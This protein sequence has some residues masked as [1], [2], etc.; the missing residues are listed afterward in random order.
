LTGTAS[1]DDARGVRA[2]LLLACGLA[3][4]PACG[5]AQH[6]LAI[7]DLRAPFV[8]RWGGEL[9]PEPRCWNDTCWSPFS[10]EITVEP[11]ET[12]DAVLVH[13]G[14]ADGSGL[15]CRMTVGS[16]HSRASA[17]Q[18]C[19]LE[20]GSSL[21][22][23]GQELVAQ[24]ELHAHLDGTLTYRWRGQWREGADAG[25]AYPDVT[26]SAQLAPTPGLAP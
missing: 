21:S 23:F 8:G 10:I 25:Y 7:R 11:G 20:V 18:A 26:W 9:I 1:F 22:R 12:P 13:H 24:L 6:G 2:C 4:V 16:D 15:V 5:G 3:L 19:A 14:D 17:D